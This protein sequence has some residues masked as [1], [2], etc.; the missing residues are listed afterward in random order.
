MI[1]EFIVC[2]TNFV[3]NFKFYNCENKKTHLIRLVMIF[4]SFEADQVFD[5]N[6]VQFLS[7]KSI[8]YVNS[9]FSHNLFCI[10]V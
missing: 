4:L 9:F 3:Y 7:E 6:K 2:L 8:L 1:T 5:E 10:Y